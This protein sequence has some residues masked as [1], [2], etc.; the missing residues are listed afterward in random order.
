MRP[1]QASAR[2]QHGLNLLVLGR[3]EDASRELSEAVRLNP[4]DPDS[5]AHLAYCEFKLGRQADARTHAAA[6]LALDSR[7]ALAQGVVQEL[8]RRE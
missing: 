8:R 6:A 1:E 4:R 2:Q 5:L 3:Y 7:H